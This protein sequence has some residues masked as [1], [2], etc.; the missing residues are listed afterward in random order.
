MNVTTM[1]MPK[2]QAKRMLREYRARLLKRNDDELRAVAEGLKWMARGRAV[3]N[4]SEAIRGGG[5]FPSGLPKL[6]ICRSDETRVEFEWRPHSSAG[7]YRLARRGRRRGRPPQNN[8]VVVEFGARH[9]K[10]Q[11]DEHW[12]AH[13]GVTLTGSAMVPLVPP[14]ALKEAH[15]GTSALGRFFTLWE[16]EKWEPVPPR[17][18][19]LLQHLGGEL[20]V[21]LAQ[22]D[23]TDIERAV[24]AGTRR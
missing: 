8:E 22:W 20:Y 1:T 13:V 5:L 15:T 24:I 18:P 23:L 4:L 11:W 14:A 10:T 17:D 7:T 12:K 9:G 3:I 21:V 6:A 16:V 19:M 2:A